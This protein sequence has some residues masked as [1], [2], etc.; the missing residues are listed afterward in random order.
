MKLSIV[1]PF[2]NE[3]A[4]L[5]ALLE[6]VLAVRLGGV[7]KEIVAVN[8]GSRDG[9]AEIAQRFA[10]EQPGVIRL[11]SFPTNGGKGRAVIAGMRQ[12]SGDI[13]IIQDADLEYEPEDY[14]LILRAYED[15]A[16]K[17]VFGSRI[18][19][20]Q[21]HLENGTSDRYSYRRY[22]WG[23]R[24]VTMAANLLYAAHLTDEPTC[25]KSLRREVLNELD[26]NS[27]G[28]E[29]CPEI[30]S[31]LLRRGYRIVE[32]PIRYNP[33][34]FA[35]GKKIRYTDGLRALWT[36]LWLRFK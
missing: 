1:I 33:R 26:L 4:T 21:Q 9:S 15:P 5:G 29:F 22:Y 7:S 28:F 14:R 19:G 32:V 31:K 16:V 20:S 3:A 13:I 35:E 8:D 2:Y 18:L 12:A 25:Y 10:R 24:L 36:L 23:G 34:S 11:L 17:V 27:Q 6:K 30:T